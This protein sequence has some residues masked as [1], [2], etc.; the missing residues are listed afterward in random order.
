MPSFKIK[1]LSIFSK[2]KRY[3]VEIKKNNKIN[4][5]NLKA[6]NRSQYSKLGKVLKNNSKILVPIKLHLGYYIGRY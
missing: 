1:K 6:K 4:D 3:T 5:V 2:I